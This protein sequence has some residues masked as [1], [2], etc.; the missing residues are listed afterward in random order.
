MK[1]VLITGGAGFIGSNLSLKLISKGYRVRVLDNLNPQIHGQNSEE[2][3]TYNLIKGKVEFV[4]GSVNNYEDLKKSLVDVD[5]VV[6]FAAETG[7]GQSMYEI[8]EYVETNI[9]GTSKLL[10]ILANE[11]NTVKKVILA[12]SR[13]VYGE[14]KYKC[15]EHGIVY[16]EERKDEHMSQGDFE[17]KCPACHKTVE[18]LPTDEQAKLHPSS[19]YGYTKLAQEHLISIVCKTI[20]IP[21]TIFRFQNVY[22]PGQSLK[23]PYTGILS[24]FSTAIK[25]N[26]DINVFEDGNET[27]DFVYIDDVID[28]VVKG[29]ENQGACNNVLNVGSNEATDVLTIAQTLTVKYKSNVKVGISGNYRFGDIRNNLA[30]LSSIERTLGYVPQVKFEEGISNFVEWVEQQVIEKDNY[31][32][33]LIEMKNKGLFK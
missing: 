30:D 14:G 29:I 1:R 6:H 2:S 18:M 9:N 10:N 4:L 11:V 16:P 12:S 33:S 28:A 21:Y 3:Y 27:R 17:V 24:I 32:E 19:V 26:N 15:D 23:N 7:T 5:V 25:N 31:Q 20:N 13:S 8:N 22:G